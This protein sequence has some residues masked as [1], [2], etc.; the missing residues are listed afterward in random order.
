MLTEVTF[1]NTVEPRG[2]TTG[3]LLLLGGIN[4]TPWALY[5][6]VIRSDKDIHVL[7]PRQINTRIQY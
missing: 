4:R 3:L 7:K 6:Y 5:F 2:C 1:Y